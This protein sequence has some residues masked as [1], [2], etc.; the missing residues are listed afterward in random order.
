MF[1][2]VPLV[3]ISTGPKTIPTI[4]ELASLIHHTIHTLFGAR[5]TNKVKRPSNIGKCAPE[6]NTDKIQL[7]QHK[8]SSGKIEG[9]DF[10]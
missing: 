4:Y 9:Y 7:V 6:K 5:V 2:F 1:Y 3:S 10:T 8:E